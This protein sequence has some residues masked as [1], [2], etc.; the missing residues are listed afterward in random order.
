MGGFA[1]VVARTQCRVKM[2]PWTEARHV[3]SISPAA[4]ATAVEFFCVFQ[5]FRR[6][7]ICAILDVHNRKRGLWLRTD[8]FVIDGG[9]VQFEG[10][11]APK[12]FM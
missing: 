2:R 6:K 8:C 10:F 3:F 7:I 9:K 5:L 12:L 11:Y 1:F 4:L